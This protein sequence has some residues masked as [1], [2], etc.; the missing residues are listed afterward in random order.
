[1]QNYA[2]SDDAHEKVKPEKRVYPSVVNFK[3]D[4][5]FEG[6]LMVQAS[7]KRTASNGSKYLD[8]T[9][10][11]KTASISSKMW[12]GSVAVPPVGLPI[13]VRGLVQ[14]YNGR[15]QFRVDKFR[16]AAETEDVP[17]DSLVPCSPSE[18]NDMLATINQVID[19]MKSTDLKNILRLLIERCGDAIMYYPA[20]QKLHHAERGGLLHH[21]TSMLKLA[22]G[23]IAAYPTLDR[24][25]LFA[26]IIAHDLAKI[27]ELNSDTYGVVHEYSVEGLLL[28]HIPRGIVNI[29]EAGKACNADAQTILLLQHMILSHHGE[30]E[31]GSPR[32][33]MFPEAEVLHT[34]DLVD[35]R[36]FEM[37]NATRR[38][39]PGSFTEKIWSL[40][41]KLY[42]IVKDNEEEH[43]N[44]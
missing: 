3:K 35:A 14:E 9:L 15:T 31:F 17:M 30:P 8:M 44:A 39:A 27:T 37:E 21:V 38:V 5:H 2:T 7:E 10:G 19:S 6:F 1:M 40:D 43:H 33:P 42:H 20:A 16:A 41:R 28:G 4:D 32:H 36:L 34:I 11:D 23:F 26:G 24:D 18:P 29:E 22:E 13:Y 25:L 12:D